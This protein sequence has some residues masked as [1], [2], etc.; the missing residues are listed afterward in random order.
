MTADKFVTVAVAGNAEHGK[1]TF[2][3]CLTGIDLD[4]YS[5][6]K[7]GPL[8]IETSST[9]FR[10]PSGVRIALVEM[11]NHSDLS[12]KTSDPLNRLDLAILVVAADEGV[13]PETKD[14]LEVLNRF[15]AQGG[16]VVISKADLVDHETIE[17]AQME[18]REISK[19]SC[20]EG[21]PVIPFSASDRRGLDQILSTME[22]EVDRV[23][24]R[25]YCSS[26]HYKAL[27]KQVLNA[28]T[29]I[30]VHKVFKVAVGLDE[31]LSRLEPAPD[32]ALLQRMLRELCSEGKLL[33]TYGGYRIPEFSIR[34][35]Q[36]RAKF[37][38]QMLEYA[39]NL[40]YVT[41]T[42]R[43]FCELHWKS[44]NVGEIRDLLEYL[45][46][47]KRLVRL[48][49]R[50]YLTA[51]AM[52]EIKEKVRDL[53]SRKGSLTIQD[54]WEILG[55]GRSRA[56]PVLEYL[57]SIGLTRR[58]EDARVLESETAPKFSSRR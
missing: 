10:L 42:A 54:G 3:R 20:L 51:E 17:L 58:I 43:T 23:D 53:I 49:D 16:L 48:K 32:Q 36:N 5:P 11:P 28:T 46:E 56:V 45:R 37:A 21:K 38:D 12:K 13:M 40:G 27:K 22:D 55:Y 33:P 7:G 31:L 6:A 26:G 47:R 30:L 35:P 19:G 2:V 34:L 1:T 41:F 39:R 9:P 52:E 18:V 44:F 57:D 8:S 29:E 25:P 14:H 24:G 50:R 4:T 15:K